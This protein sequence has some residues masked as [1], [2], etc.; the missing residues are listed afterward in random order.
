MARAEARAIAVM[1]LSAA[2]RSRAGVWAGPRSDAPCAALEDAVH[3][4]TDEVGSC[5]NRAVR[6]RMEQPNLVEVVSGVKSMRPL[7]FWAMVA[8]VALGMWVFAVSAGLV[9]L[10]LVALG[11]SQT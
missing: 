2:P 4:T 9:F 7:S 6:W 1:E 8:A 11:L 10:A 3:A 5:R